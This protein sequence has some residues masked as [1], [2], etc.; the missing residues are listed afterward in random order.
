[1]FWIS[2]SLT[3]C[4]IWKCFPLF[5]PQSVVFCLGC[6][7][8]GF[9]KSIIICWSS[10]T[11]LFNT[12]WFSLFFIYCFTSSQHVFFLFSSFVSLLIWF[13]KN[14]P[15]PT[16]SDFNS[17]VFSV[18]NLPASFLLSLFGSVFNHNLIKKR[19]T[20]LSHK[21]QPSSP[22][23]KSAAVQISLPRVLAGSSWE[24]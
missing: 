18:P 20:N 4:F 9:S 6:F 22:S 8:P 13:V 3:S 2:V 12:S 19:C 21:S 10:V 16:T 5:I 11:T 24:I 7:S 17:S 1:M 23:V 15:P 14:S